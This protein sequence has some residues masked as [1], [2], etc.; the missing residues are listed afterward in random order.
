[1]YLAKRTGQG[2]EADILHGL[3]VP[4]KCTSSSLLLTLLSRSPVLAPTCK[5]HEKT[6]KERGDL[7][8]ISDCC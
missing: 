4:R 7:K 5:E 3:D 1:M 6:K 2:C 8:A